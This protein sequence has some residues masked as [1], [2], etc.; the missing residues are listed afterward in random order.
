[1]GK[2]SLALLLGEALGAKVIPEVARTLCHQL[3]YQ[4]PAEIPDQKVFREEVTRQ[5]IIQENDAEG[6]VADRGTIDAW[7]MWQRWQLCSAMTFDTEAYY[8]RCREQS[9]RYTHVIYIPPLFVP[10]E[11]AFRWTDPDYIKQV[12]RLT[13]MTLYDWALWDRTY[14]VR[15][16]EPAERV[17]EVKSWLGLL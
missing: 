11:D 4:S 10:P 3:G 16:T 7:V 2:T 5:Q 15:T 17:T 6:F 13:R 1:M 14:T 12:D 8:E 9:A